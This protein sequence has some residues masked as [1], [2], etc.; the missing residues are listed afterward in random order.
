MNTYDER[1][2]P[3]DPT[4]STYNGNNKQWQLV[5]GSYF[6]DVPQNTKEY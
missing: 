3:M 1:A 6:Y 2:M 4:H 5:V